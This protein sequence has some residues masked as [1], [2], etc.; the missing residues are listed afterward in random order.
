MEEQVVLGAQE[1]NGFRAVLQK[2]DEN[3]LLKALLRWR[4]FPAQVYVNFAREKLLGRICL[5]WPAKLHFWSENNYLLGL[6]AFSI[7]TISLCLSLFQ[8]LVPI[9]LQKSDLL[10]QFNDLVCV[11]VRQHLFYDSREDFLLSGENPWV[12]GLGVV[13]FWNVQLSQTEELGDTACILLLQ[14]QAVCDQ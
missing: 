12:P 6:T 3:T 1:D 13:D 5:E 10:N 9:F 4:I 2:F 8:S 7:Y 14:K 11:A